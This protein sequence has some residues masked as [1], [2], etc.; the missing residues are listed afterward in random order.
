MQS[1]PLRRTHFGQYQAAFFGSIMFSWPQGRPSPPSITPNG[2]YS[3]NIEQPPPL[4]IR[5]PDRCKFLKA[6]LQI[7]AKNKARL[8]IKPFLTHLPIIIITILHN[9]M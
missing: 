2:A 8:M 5:D 3:F 9:I 6:A 4:H 7:C 1:H